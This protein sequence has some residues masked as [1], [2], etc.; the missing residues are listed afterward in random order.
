MTSC[1]DDLEFALAIERRQIEGFVD[2]EPDRLGIDAS[3]NCLV[4]CTAT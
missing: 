1:S 3:R 2:G 4:N